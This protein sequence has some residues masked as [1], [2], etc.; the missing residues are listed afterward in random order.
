MAMDSAV[1]QSSRERFITALLSGR[2]VFIFWMVLGLVHATYR[3]S[4]SGTL[5]LDDSRVS[6]LVQSFAWGYQARQPPLY[7]WLIWCVQQLIGIGLQSF[8]LVRYTLFA[9]LGYAMYAATRHAVRDERLAALA[10]ISISANYQIGWSFHETGTQSMVLALACFWTFDAAMRF[11]S[12]SSLP[13]ALWL[14]AAVGVGF[15]SKHSYAL[16]LVSLILAAL[17]LPETRQ[18]LFDRRLLVSAAVALVLVSPYVIWLA[19][20]GGDVIASSEDTLIDEPLGHGVRALHGLARLARS[21]PSFLLPWIAVV[22]LFAPSALVRAPASAVP[23]TLT[24]RLA[25]R[26]IACAVALAAIGIATIGATNIGERYMYALLVITPIYVFARIDRLAASEWLI[27]HL[28]TFCVSCAV[29]IFCIRVL[30]LLNNGV[31]NTDPYHT[32]VP[33]DQLARALN[34]RGL[35]EGTAIARNIRI[36]GNLRVVLP[37]LRVIAPDSYRVECPPLRAID[38]RKAFAV[39]MDTGEDW[40]VHG[41]AALKGLPRERIVTH[42]RRTILGGVAPQTWTVV[43]LVPPASDTLHV[44]RRAATMRALRCQN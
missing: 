14:G 27:V 4:Y 30:S 1:S 10:S 13:H 28:T 33:Y 16:F 42:G 9:L 8:L 35:G 36:A 29:A 32:L 3:F 24:E 22:V 25:G 17:S 41:L 6:E 34:A 38:E 21:I 11:I 7:E 12:R 18:R 26:T 31:V 43:R 20:T 5:A 23:P 19:Q 40:W 37:S 44:A 39:W 2:G 15:L